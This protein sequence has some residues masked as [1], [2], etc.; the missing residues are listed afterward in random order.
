MMD[1]R[2]NR[3]VEAIVLDEAH[4]DPHTNSL[5]ELTV[6]GEAHMGATSH[7]RLLSRWCFQI[8]D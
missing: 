3:L 7:I 5:G 6:L 4:M 8:Q 2:V 1:L